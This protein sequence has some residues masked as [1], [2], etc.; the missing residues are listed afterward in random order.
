MKILLSAI[1]CHPELG[2]ESGVGWKAATALSKEHSL[3]VLT[4][5]GE[6]EGIESALATGAYPNLSF[7]FF[8]TDAPYHKNRLIARLQSWK[9]YVDWTR[10]SLDIARKLAGQQ[11]FD[12]AHHVTY[13]SWRIPS[14]L[15]QLN[16]P[17]VWGPVG[18]AA[19]YPLH[20]LGKLAVRSA[21]FEILRGLS[22][23]HA[24]YSRSLKEC[25]CN[26]DAVVASNRETLDKLL[27]LQGRPERIHLLF[28]TFFTDQ[29][30]AMFRCDPVEKPHAD[31][32]RLFAGGNI[33]GS[34]GLIFALEALKIAAQTGTK[35][36]L[37]VGGYGPEIPFLRKKA[38]TLGIEDWIEFH[39]GFSG[40]KYVDKLKQ[41]HIFILPSFRENA[42]ITMLEAMLAGCVPVIIDASAQAGVVND[43]CGFKIPVGRAA[44]I[45]EGLASAV[46]L[47]AQQPEQ[48]MEM[49]RNA[50]KLVAASFNEDSYISSINKVYTDALQRQQKQSE[51]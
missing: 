28:P 50:S 3:H 51:C 4:S 42:G 15:W 33:I 30:L 21:I 13:S 29:Q 19:V 24:S 39:M 34:K 18:G 47:L 32:V 43:R 8:G 16:L 17:F 38:R 46:G 31:P 41:S 2:S 37:T 1:A 44:E 26:S 20:L 5:E 48:R 40:A 7:T 45:S 22:N 27:S 35:W 10:Q 36:R 12:L 11:H 23:L 6:R 25:V 49:G 14:P 9:R